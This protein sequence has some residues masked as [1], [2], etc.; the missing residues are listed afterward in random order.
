[1]LSQVNEANNIAE[2]LKRN[3][4][5]MLKMVATKGGSA[6]DTQVQVTYNGN[7]ETLWDSETF[8]DR[9]YEMRDIYDQFV[10]HGRDLTSVM[11]FL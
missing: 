2:E 5:F 10:A 1:M 11:C 7:E 9:V 6:T 4:N 8:L 3:V